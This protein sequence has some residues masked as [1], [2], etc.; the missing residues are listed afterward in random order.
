LK[1]AL[2]NTAQHDLY[3]GSNQTGVKVGPGRIGSGRIDLAL[4]ANASVLAYSADTSGAVNVSFSPIDVPI[5]GPT[6]TASR[7]LKVV[8]KGATAQAYT[9][10]FVSVGTDVPGVTFSVPATVS[11]PAS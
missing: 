7:T 2:M 5:D 8:N 6:L 11:V 9:A 10:S 3:T 1:A 4:A